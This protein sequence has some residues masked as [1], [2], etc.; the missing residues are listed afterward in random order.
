MLLRIGA[1]AQLVI[2]ETYKS[3]HAGDVLSTSGKQPR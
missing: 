2:T 1:L 3:T